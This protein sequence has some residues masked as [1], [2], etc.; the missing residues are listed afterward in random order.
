MAE[1]VQVWRGK[2]ADRENLFGPL[3]GLRAGNVVAYE[4][5]LPT[6]GR[7]YRM[8][9][10]ARVYSRIVRSASPV[11]NAG[12]MERLDRTRRDTRAGLEPASR[13]RD[14]DKGDRGGDVEHERAERT[15]CERLDQ[16]NREDHTCRAQDERLVALVIGGERS[17]KHEACCDQRKER[18]APEQHV[19]QRMRTYRGR[20]DVR[21]AHWEA[22]ARVRVKERTTDKPEPADTQQHGSPD[23]AAPTA[24]RAS[25]TRRVADEQDPADQEIGDLDA[26]QGT[27]LEGADG[28]SGDLEAGHREHLDQRHH[29]K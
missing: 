1:R 7:H 21:R 16:S 28:V 27:G 5:E 17:G 26:A 13:Q 11:C 20:N 8:L 12:A 4:F 15:S 29:H 22:Q 2:H 18:E 25:H 3:P 9:D 6:D 10:L 24:Q 19:Q 23:S 14:R